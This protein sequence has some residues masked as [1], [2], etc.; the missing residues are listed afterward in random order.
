MPW[1]SVT[2]GSATAGMS[3]DARDPSSSTSRR[4]RPR[5]RPTPCPSARRPTI[6]SPGASR[7]TSSAWCMSRVGQRQPHGPSPAGQRLGQEEAV[8][9]HQPVS[10]SL[11]FCERRRACVALPR[12]RAPSDSSAEQ[13]LL[14]LR[15]ASSAPPP[16][17]ARSRSPRPE[18]RRRGM[19]SP[20]TRTVS[21]YC[22]PAGTWIVVRFRAGRTRRSRRRGPPAR[23]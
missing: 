22:A 4:R 17:G 8:A 3:R 2:S 7:S 6:S 12:R 14:P 1:T 15:S 5:A 13:L 16:R 10:Q 20:L 9:G 23:C 21:P 18:P 11:S 19:P